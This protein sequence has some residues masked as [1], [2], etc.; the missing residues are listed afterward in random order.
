MLVNVAHTTE[1]YSVSKSRHTP[2]FKQIKHVF[3]CFLK[4]FIFSHILNWVVIGSSVE[5]QLKTSLCIDFKS[6]RQCWKRNV[7]VG[8]VHSVL[9]PTV[10]DAA[11]MFSELV[12]K[13]NSNG[14]QGKHLNHEFG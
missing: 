2:H 12:S 10:D 6:N 7:V 14:G 11:D 9:P 3:V 1:L 4:Y 13:F 5:T 8:D